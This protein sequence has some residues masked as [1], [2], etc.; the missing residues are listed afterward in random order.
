MKRG[1]GIMLKRDCRKA[2]LYRIIAEKYVTKK[3]QIQEEA[4]RLIEEARI[5]YETELLRLDE[6]KINENN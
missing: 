4:D 6:E 1:C 2:Q 3:T 5:A